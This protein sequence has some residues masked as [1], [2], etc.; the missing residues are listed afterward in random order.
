MEAVTYL[1]AGDPVPY[2]T[3]SP[4]DRPHHVGIT[5][6]YELPFGKGRR[7]LAGAPAPLRV[8]VDGWQ[9]GVVMN[10]WSGSPIS[11]GDVIFNGGIDAIAL[12]KGQRTVERWFN[13]DAGFKRASAK[14]LSYHRFAGPLYYSGVR[15]D[16]TDTWYM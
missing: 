11:F 5:A 7:L 9:I 8:L 15:T 6:L 14:Q 10:S 4:N 13:V 2:R 12:P 16:G 1:N 3:I